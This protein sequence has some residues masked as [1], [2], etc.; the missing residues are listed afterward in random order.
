[1]GKKDLEQVV[2]EGSTV[3][4]KMEV[5]AFNAIPPANKTVFSGAC[6]TELAFFKYLT[7]DDYEALPET[8]FTKVFED[9][10]AKFD[11]DKVT[12]VEL[13]RVSAVSLI[14]ATL[15]FQ[16]SSLNSLPRCLMRVVP[17]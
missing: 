4:G 3:C 17:F 12:D 7:K 13:P 2:A 1:M 6:V 16:L 5:E 14:V 15:S 8:A 11:L 9:E 10:D